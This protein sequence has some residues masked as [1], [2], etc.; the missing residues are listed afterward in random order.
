MTHANEK[1]EHFKA[2]KTGIEEMVSF[3]LIARGI[4][5]M[6][7]SDEIYV[8]VVDSHG[9]FKIRRTLTKILDEFKIQYDKRFLPRIDLK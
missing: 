5:K 4:N 7:G 2:L 8:K 9:L 1:S 3:N 6:K